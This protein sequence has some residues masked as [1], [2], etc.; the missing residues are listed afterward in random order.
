ME[1]LAG[2]PLRLHP[3]LILAQV[4]KGIRLATDLEDPP[5]TI[6]SND[7]RSLNRQR[8]LPTRPMH[9]QNARRIT[10][11]AI[12]SAHGPN[13]TTPKLTHRMHR[14]HADICPARPVGEQQRP[15]TQINTRITILHPARRQLT[16]GIPQR[17][18]PRALN[19]PSLTKPITQP[20]R[21]P[22]M[23]NLEKP[24]LLS[25]HPTTTRR[26][27]HDGWPV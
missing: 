2:E 8:R 26:K 3:L 21:Q 11:I 22:H 16:H 17:P 24:N 13:R 5:A 18:P 19:A 4:L 20:T 15:P 6:I 23:P 25:N 12:R 27:H 7:D 9:R 1:H 14:Q 10:R